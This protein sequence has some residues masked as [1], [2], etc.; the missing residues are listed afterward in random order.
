M[1]TRNKS[2]LLR[3]YLVSVLVCAASTSAIAAPVYMPPSANLVYGDVTHGQRVLSASG[4]P[5]AAAVDVVRGGGK[6]VSGTV[7]SGGAGMEYGNVQDLFDT[8]DFL[9]TAF[10]PTGPGSAPPPGQKPD[11]KPPGVDIGKIIDGI[12][13]DLRALIETATV[14]I[15]VMGS[16]LAFISADGY[17]KAFVQADAPVVIGRELLGGA[18]TFGV[19]WSG[20]SKAFGLVAPIEFDPDT[21]L[22]ALENA[23]DLMPGDPAKIFDLSGDGQVLMRINPNS[24]SVCLALDND[25]SMVT[26]SSQ[27]TEIDVGY[28]RQVW[29]TRAGSLFLGGEASLYMMKLSRATARFG[30]ITD[31]DELFDSIR[32]ADYRNDTKMGLDLGALWVADQY[33]LG[34]HVTNLNEPEFEFPDLNLDFYKNGA[35]KAFLIADQTYTAERQWKFESSVFSTDR[36]WTVNLGVDANAVPDPMNDDYQW[37]TVS[38]GYAT[39]KWWLPGIRAG[40]RKNLAGT[41]IGYVGLGLTALKV[42]NIDIASA[43]DTVSI[44]GT[45]LPRGLM[46]SIGFQIA[47]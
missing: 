24:G 44:S 28:S 7:I 31:S 32:N 18:W 38:A 36:K 12:D 15:A 21:A 4:N 29:P 41:E 43:L 11:E 9:A 13:P 10:V 1:T 5:A 19:N 45:E 17:G 6:S 8:V 20:T 35:V 46:A 27:T 3:Q 25:T 47:W 16:I 39:N 37:L 30:D 14:E 26:K 2:S 33:Q 40:L 34:L 22:T 23:Y 42:V